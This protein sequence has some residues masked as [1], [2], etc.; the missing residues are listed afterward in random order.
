MARC[1]YGHSWGGQGGLLQKYIPGL[2][3][4]PRRLN[5]QGWPTFLTQMELTYEEK[6]ALPDI[7]MKNLWLEVL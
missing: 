6:G 5:T 7:T 4:S 2:G 1:M 3:H